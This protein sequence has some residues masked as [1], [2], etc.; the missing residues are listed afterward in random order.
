MRNITKKIGLT[1]VGICIVLFASNCGGDRTASGREEI[2]NNGEE[3]SGNEYLGHLPI[4][5]ANYFEEYDSIMEE[6]ETSTERDP[7]L[8]AEFNM[9]RPNADDAIEEYLGNNSFRNL[10]FEQE[11]NDPFNVEE[12]WVESANTYDFNIKARVILTEETSG[13]LFAYVKAVDK[14]GHELGR[15]LGILIYQGSDIN[16]VNT[17]IELSGSIAD[18]AALAEFDKFIF[19][20]SE[21][22]NSLSA[23]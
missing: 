17:E 3:Q 15:S 11:T 5:A 20:S 1:V 8:G 14:E 7:S 22:M 13:M 10:P 2:A 12:I 19:I 18:L 21:E 23:Q 4:M 9:L 16:G 6:M